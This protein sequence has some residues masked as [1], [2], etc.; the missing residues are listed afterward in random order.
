VKRGFT[1]LAFTPAVEQAQHRLGARAR[2]RDLE[3]LDT[4]RDRITADLAAFIAAGQLFPGNGEPR[5]SALYPA[6]RRAAGLPR[7]AR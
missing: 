6:S 3:N 7:R 1:R 2:N 5:R 4:G